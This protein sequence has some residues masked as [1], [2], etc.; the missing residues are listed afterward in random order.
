MGTR[1]PR[2]PAQ[3]RD[4][5]RSEH[6]PCCTE[7]A[8]MDRVKD[9]INIHNKHHPKDPGTDDAQ[10]CITFPVHE[11]QVAEWNGER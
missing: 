11:H 2:L 9:F 1:S 6:Y 10:A 4:A 7:K 8:D 5:L 3:V